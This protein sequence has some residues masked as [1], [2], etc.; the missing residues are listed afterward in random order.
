MNKITNKRL[1]K[2][3][4]VYGAFESVTSEA[5]SSVHSVDRL[6]HGRIILFICE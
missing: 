3:V 5:R 1:F 2:K 4:S 6:F